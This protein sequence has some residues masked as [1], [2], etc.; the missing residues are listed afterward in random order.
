MGTRRGPIPTRQNPSGYL[1]PT[2]SK[3]LDGTFNK[4]PA[5]DVTRR[6]HDKKRLYNV[7]LNAFN[8][9]THYLCADSFTLCDE[10]A[11]YNRMHKHY[12]GHTEADINR[13]YGLTMG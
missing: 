13:L 12:Y 1:E 5:D 6:A 4:V 3:N 10:I 2:T 8:E 9:S 11:I 7:M